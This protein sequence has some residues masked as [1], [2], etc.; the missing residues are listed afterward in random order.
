MRVLSYRG[1]LML[2]AIPG[3][4]LVVLMSVAY[5]VFSV[6]DAGATLVAASFCFMCFSLFFIV[7]CGMRYLS[8]DI[9]SAAYSNQADIVSLVMPFS[10]LPTTRSALAVASLSPLSPLPLDALRKVSLASLLNVKD[11]LHPSHPSSLSSAALHHYAFA[12]AREASIAIIGSG[13]TA[14]AAARRLIDGGVPASRVVVLE[15]SRFVGGQHGALGA[16][17]S[18]WVAHEPESDPSGD[19]GAA[20]TPA[21]SSLSSQSPERASK[22]S[23]SEGGDSLP[24][25]MLLLRDAGGDSASS[26]SF[27]LLSRYVSAAPSVSAWHAFVS[28]Q[29]G[30]TNANSSSSLPASGSGSP[31]TAV[32]SCAAWMQAGRALH[33]AEYVRRVERSSIAASSSRLD[34]NAV[35]EGRAQKPNQRGPRTE[36]FSNALDRH[37]EHASNDAHRND[38]DIDSFTSAHIRHLFAR[39]AVSPDGSV[40]PSLALN[41]L[42]D[43]PVVPH[44]VALIDGAALLLRELIEGPPAAAIA[45]QRTGTTASGAQGRDKY[46]DAKRAPL[47]DSLP[48]LLR[49]LY[50]HLPPPRGDESLERIA[51][52]RID[53]I[54][55]DVGHP[56]IEWGARRRAHAAEMKEAEAAAANAAKAALAAKAA[57]EELVSESAQQPSD[58]ESAVT[59]PLPTPAPA[60]VVR[61]RPQIAITLK[62]SEVTFE[63]THPFSVLAITLACIFCVLADPF[64]SY[65]YFEI[66][67]DFHASPPSSLINQA[68]PFSELHR[69]GRARR[70]SHHCERRRPVSG[71]LHR[72]HA[73]AAAAAFAPLTGAHTQ[74]PLGAAATRVRVGL[75]ESA[76]AAQ[77]H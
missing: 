7:S 76:A 28:Y 57:A 69:P 4:F 41:A 22:P 61:L 77:I 13:I 65:F 20:A 71:R 3:A 38:N 64:P 73:P 63:S 39:D 12:S 15:P 40:D 21:S 8:P 48:P 70:L 67:V 74:R 55:V 17:S 10:P 25:D 16:S 66:R 1:L 56:T 53:N 5:S 49:H 29:R 9:G 23:S 36:S 75:L 2:L 35:E 42:I 24:I 34:S 6:P 31:S 47:S 50:G 59:A 52:N 26:A 46:H 68:L 54:R 27:T 37:A 45:K 11:A 33:A 43:M 72:P 62:S 18:A 32:V 58:R 14:L 51:A 19:N 44:D 30:Q 60:P